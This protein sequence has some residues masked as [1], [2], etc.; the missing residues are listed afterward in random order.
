M[1]SR[2]YACRH[3]ACRLGRRWYKKQVHALRGHIGLKLKTRVALASP[4]PCLPP[5]LPGGVRFA[6]WSPKVS[7]EPQVGE[8]VQSSHGWKQCLHLGVWVRP[9]GQPTTCT[10]STPHGATY[11]V[12]IE[13]APRGNLRHEHRLRP[14]GQRT[15]WTSSTPPRGNLRR[16]HRVRPPRH[17]VNIEYA[18]RGNLR[19]KHRV[20]PPGQ[21]TA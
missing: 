10:S 13:Y 18:P 11:G 6:L 19:R 7:L 12:N 2:Q 17:H 9:P 20:R 5:G 1:V 21:P 14:T 3:K 4:P 15:V 8:S 16:E